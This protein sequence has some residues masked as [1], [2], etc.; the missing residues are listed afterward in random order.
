MTIGK[1]TIFLGTLISLFSPILSSA[2]V[3]WFAVATEPVRPYQFTDWPVLAWLVVG[4]AVITLGF[5]LQKRI[6]VLSELE[7]RIS[8]LASTVLSLA[9]IGF[10]LAFLL[11]TMN[12]FIF[13]PNLV[14]HDTFAFFLLGI[15]AVAGVMILVGW[16][17]RIGAVLIVAL[18]T[19]C[20]KE[21]GVF[22]M[23]DTLE[24]VG[25]ALYVLF[26]GRPRWH[27][28]EW[29]WLR[30]LTHRLRVYSVPVLRVSTGLNLLVLAFTEKILAPELSQNFL[31]THDWNF[32]Q[33][34]GFTW[35]SNYW[36]AFSAGAAE[37][38]IG[39]FL[40]MG[41]LTRLTTLALVGFL[42]TTLVLLGPIEL[43]G[44]L[45][46]FSITIVLLVFGAGARLKVR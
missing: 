35:Y 38:L 17:E 26:V 34:L 28:S 16:Y 1:K 5:Y 2:H 23:L 6:P 24:M 27:L 20:M 33:H 4:L 18:F 44:H 11:F 3:K 39:I 14:P 25:F 32:M 37:A 31:S 19:L 8:S 7:R 40:I 43:V 22:E 46:H 15:Q 45:P 42:A 30:D 13:A 36:F 12:G 21:F 10:G 9:N 29:G 41:L